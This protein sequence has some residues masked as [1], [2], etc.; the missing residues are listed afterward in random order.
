LH[1][2]STINNLERE[3]ENETLDET[4]EDLSKFLNDSACL[5]AENGRPFPNIHSPG[6]CHSYFKTLLFFNKNAY[7]L[8]NTFSKN[9]KP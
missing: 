4:N 2:H 9:K 5:E 1:E 6:I 3:I 7:I 8:K